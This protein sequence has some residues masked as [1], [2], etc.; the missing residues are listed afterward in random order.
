MSFLKFSW[1]YINLCYKPTSVRGERLE[2]AQLLPMWS[3]PRSILTPTEVI[4]RP[5]KNLYLHRESW[6]T[7]D[8]CY[9]STVYTYL[10][11][12]FMLVF[13]CTVWV[14]SVLLIMSPPYRPLARGGSLKKVDRKVEL[15]AT[16]STA[17]PEIKFFLHR[18]LCRILIDTLV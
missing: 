6:A 12:K 8:A 2:E 14:R 1:Y 3:D 13:A 7:G 17:F 16:P 15:P 11:P 10:A 5:N 4:T 9:K 18:V